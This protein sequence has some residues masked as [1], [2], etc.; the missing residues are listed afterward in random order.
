MAWVK[1]HTEFMY[2]MLPCVPYMRHVR[3]VTKKKKEVYIPKLYY[4]TWLQQHIK[5]YG[6][7]APPEIALPGHLERHSLKCRGAD[8][9][10]IFEALGVRMGWIQIIRCRTFWFVRFR[11]TDDM[12]VQLLLSDSLVCLNFISDSSGTGGSRHIDKAPEKETFTVSPPW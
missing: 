5:H 4:I 12:S 1:L 2:I 11:G 7:G 8:Q 6:G 10:A 9:A 3:C